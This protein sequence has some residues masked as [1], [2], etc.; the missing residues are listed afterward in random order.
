MSQQ[1][2]IDGL[3]AQ[4]E[5]NA[6]AAK[7]MFQTGHYDWCL[8]IWHLV[9]EKALKALIY[10]QGKTPPYIHDLVKLAR[11][12]KIVLDDKTLKQL[13]TINE[14]NLEAR[15]DDEKLQFYQKATQKF[16]LKWAAVCEEKCQW[17]L[18]QL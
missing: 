2:S 13:K 17:L 8:F 18:K 14:F 1:E 9:L 4:A 10:G 3:L 5:N 7:S 16:A 11:I 6:R 12:A 15:C